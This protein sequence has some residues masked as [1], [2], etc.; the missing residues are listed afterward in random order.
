MRSSGDGDDGIGQGNN[1]ATPSDPSRQQHRRDE[2]DD[3]FGVVYGESSPEGVVYGEPSGEA[4]MATAHVYVDESADA[5]DS[6]DTDS[7]EYEASTDGEDD[8]TSNEGNDDNNA[9]NNT[10]AAGGAD[11]LGRS[12][13]QSTER[14]RGTAPLDGSFNSNPFAALAAATAAARERTFA[15]APGGDSASDAAS[16]TPAEVVE[17]APTHMTPTLLPRSGDTVVLVGIVKKPELNGTRGTVMPLSGWKGDRVGVRSAAVAHRQPY[18]HMH[19]RTHAH[20]APVRHP[21]FIC[22]FSLLPSH[23]HWLDIHGSSA[24]LLTSAHILLG[25]T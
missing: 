20:T 17:E 6:S 4:P 13:E 3:E 16:A 21:H 24:R 1:N 9:D 5:P 19:A 8:T 25:Q 18:T 15:T 22:Y 12:P 14:D 2:D 23:M 7:T 11:V 10:R